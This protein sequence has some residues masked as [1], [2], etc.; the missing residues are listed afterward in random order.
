MR[1]MKDDQR[2]NICIRNNTPC[3][4]CTE[5]FM[6]CSDCCPKDER[7]EFGYRA[8]KAENKRV[9]QERKAYMDKRQDDM[10]R[11]ETWAIKK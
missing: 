2:I 3:K 8:W 4:G 9:N 1:L 6:A 10:K 11:R 5:R 7:G